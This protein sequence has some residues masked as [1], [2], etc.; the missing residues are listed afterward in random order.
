MIKSALYCLRRKGIVVSHVSSGN[1][2]KPPRRDT[3]TSK[4]SKHKLQAIICTPQTATTALDGHGN[5]YTKLI[6]VITIFPH[7]PCQNRTQPKYHHYK[8]MRITTLAKAIIFIQRTLLQFSLGGKKG[9]SR[10][11]MVNFVVHPIENTP[12]NE[13]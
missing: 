2:Q 4:A 10:P 9:T 13:L 7:L 1:Q 11:A 3:S 6:A 8:Y 12:L 5:A